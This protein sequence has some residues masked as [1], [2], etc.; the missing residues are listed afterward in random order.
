MQFSAKSF[1]VRKCPVLLGHKSNAT[2]SRAQP[3]RE[4]KAGRDRWVSAFGPRIVMSINCKLS[5]NPRGSCL[6]KYCS[7]LQFILE[8]CQRKN[9]WEDS[10]LKEPLYRPQ[11]GQSFPAADRRG[12]GQA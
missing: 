5:K 3:G 10:V 6:F 9:W 12:G 8:C 7:R 2:A 4:D 11:E 1:F